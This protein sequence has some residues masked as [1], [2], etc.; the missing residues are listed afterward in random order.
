M[1]LPEF[2]FVTVE[3]TISLLEMGGNERRAEELQPRMPHSAA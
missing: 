2:A 3:G 1:M